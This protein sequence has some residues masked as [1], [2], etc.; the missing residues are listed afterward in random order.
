MEKS[1]RIRL[2]EQMENESK[3][4]IIRNHSV[5]EIEAAIH[6][7]NERLASHER[8]WFGMEGTCWEREDRESKR[9]MLRKLLWCFN[10]KVQ[11]LYASMAA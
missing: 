2:F 11:I 6:V 3:K 9:N 1:E 7:A 4:K 5:M 8:E 10:A